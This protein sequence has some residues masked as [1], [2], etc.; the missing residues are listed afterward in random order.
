MNIINF[1]NEI[2]INKA[3]KKFLFIA[4]CFEYNKY[5]NSLYNNSPYYISN[6]PIQL[7]ATCNGYQHLSLLIASD[8]LQGQ[9]NLFPSDSNT[10][11]KDFYR[12]VSL[13]PKELKR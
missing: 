1:N 3:E 8:P 6:Y 12:Y 13:P 5:K 4:F 10:A 11:P 9:L 7:D 2:L